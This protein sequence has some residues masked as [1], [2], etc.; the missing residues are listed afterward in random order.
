[1]EAQGIIPDAT[2]ASNKGEYTCTVRFTCPICKNFIYYKQKFCC[3][4][5]S[6]FAW[7]KWETA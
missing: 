3:E 7:K 2:V 4:C 6:K 5:G 1:M